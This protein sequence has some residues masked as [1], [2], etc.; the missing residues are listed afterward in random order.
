MKPNKKGW[1]LLGGG[2]VLLEGD[3]CSKY[4]MD[5]AVFIKMIFCTD[6]LFV[7]TYTVL[8]KMLSNVVKTQNI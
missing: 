6:L 3:Y 7:T 5:F 2:G 1:P 8:Y 4:A